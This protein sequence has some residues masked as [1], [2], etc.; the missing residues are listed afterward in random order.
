M[1]TRARRCSCS[2]HVPIYHMRSIA[3]R[4]PSFLLTS[5]NQTGS[6]PPRPSYERN[7][8][9]QLHCSSASSR[10]AGRHSNNSNSPTLK[11]RGR[12]LRP[13]RSHPTSATILSSFPHHNTSQGRS[14]SSTSAAMTASKID[15]TAIAKKIREKLHAEI[16]GQQK[17]NPRYRPSLKII[18]GIMNHYTLCTSITDFFLQWVIARIRV[19]TL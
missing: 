11:S 7:A 17:I 4:P 14:F 9:K 6:P 19:C 18:Q 2:H 3:S 15:G 1:L 16:E 8:S 12:N 13:C 5:T 10:V